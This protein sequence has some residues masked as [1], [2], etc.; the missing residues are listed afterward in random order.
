MPQPPSTPF[1]DAGTGFHHGATGAVK[2][3][4]MHYHRVEDL[5]QPQP[6]AVPH[7][8]CLAGQGTAQPR[9]VSGPAVA[10][11][12]GRTGQH[13]RAGLLEVPGEQQRHHRADQAAGGGF[14]RIVVEGI[15]RRGTA[16]GCCSTPLRPLRH[17]QLIMG[18][19]EGRD[20][21]RRFSQLPRAQGRIQHQL[22]R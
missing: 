22:G 18:G 13:R 6:F 8:D 14:H 2:R 17:T 15:D 11:G 16:N 7:Q 10:G 20:P 21:G 19:I 9:L 1:G 5:Q 3:P 4:G 12:L